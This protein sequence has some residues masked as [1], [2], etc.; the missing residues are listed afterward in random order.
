[1]KTPTLLRA[2]LLLATVLLPGLARAQGPN[3]IANPGFE[4]GGNAGFTSDY[5]YVAAP[6]AST[7][8]GSYTVGA[9]NKV[10]DSALPA[11]YG[12][13]TSGT[14]N[15]LIADGA[16]T[17]DPAPVKTVW[18]QDITGLTPNR[19]YTFSFW[20]MNTN[21]G[22][23]ASKAQI[24]A[25]ANDV[26][27]GLPYTN[28]DN[29]GVWNRYS[30]QVNPGNST[31]FTL[32]LR[33]LNLNSS[34]NDFGLD[35]L[36]LVESTADVTTTLTGPA[37]LGAG[38]SSGS[39][40]VT[41]TNNGPQ[42]AAQVTR[43]VALPAG[44][45]LT[46]A[47][48][49][50]LPNTAVYDSGLNTIT[51]EPVAILPSSSGATFAFSF[52]SPTALGNNSLTST[53]GTSTPQGDNK[54][55]D[56]ST[57]NVRVKASIAFVT[58][59]DSNEVPANGSKS[60][61]VILNDAN[62]AN[63][64]NS[65]FSAQV[66]TPPANGSL[67]LNA[68]GSYTYTPVV[69][70]KGPDSFTY[71]VNVPGANPQYSNVST[72]ALNVYQADL[73]CTSGTGPN[74]L[75]NPSFT[76]AS[77][78]AGYT[79]AYDYAGAGANSLVPE[80]LYMVGTDAHNYHN[81]FVGNG[82]KGAG[83]NFMIVN[84]SQ[85]LS[86]VYQQTV[87]VQ[88][89][90]YYTFSAYASSVNMESPAQLGFVI[91]GKSTSSVTTL[92][93]GPNAF[94]KI[95]DL[96]FSGESTQAV[97]EIRDV[98]KV[99]GGNDFGLDDLYIGTCTVYLTANDVLNPGISNQASAISVQPMSATV[100]NGGPPVGTFTVQTLPNPIAGTLYL[101]ASAVIPGQVITAANAGQLTFDPAANYTGSAVFTYSATD[102]SGS[103]SNNIAT[104]TIPID[105]RPLPVELTAFEVHAVRNLDAHLTW[106]TAQ[107]HKND[108]FDVERSFDGV[109]FARV[110]TVG[111]QGN[112]SGPTAYAYTDAG[113]GAAHTST[114]Y[115][116][117]RQVDH[118]NSATRSPV[119]TVAFE[120]AT[121]LS[122]YPNPTTGP[123]SLDLSALPAG[124]YQVTLVDATGR[125]VL[126]TA[127][128]GGQRHALPLAGLARGTYLLVVRGAGTKLSQHLVR[129]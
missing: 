56:A 102:E 87:T 94:V 108:H 41:F 98:N 38:V 125:Q 128:A 44:A 53:V 15:Y 47:Q 14:G 126:S 26:D 111:G 31:T 100:T 22:S 65:A 72:V 74:L 89:G 107:E 23:L 73:V 48:Q 5:F 118:D 97:I 95:S 124:N 96:W 18:A 68:N 42:A 71:K 6:G 82:R 63:L 27:T 29:A 86:V 58:N 30:V 84:G 13:H 32:R 91:N 12:D 61:N 88:A 92:G 66:V 80:G 116:R 35:D 90:R 62:P 70:Y 115:Y 37:V 36:E 52:T 43:V 106:T 20:L 28:A 75:I 1:M 105:P 16:A 120:G 69:D 34:A 45:S 99:K 67:T 119:R 57:V 24:Q 4:A 79:S 104:F 77:A 127:L 33:D 85:N 50:A 2:G 122:L 83:D 17:V 49:S 103:G 10:F 121:A 81:N 3:L 101:N 40:T 9:D 114:V 11:S 78:G 64:A 59:D 51:F 109:S 60:G 39:Y 25:S 112:A 8:P 76:N 21:S 55:P 54:A 113:V 46:V 110:A 19:F 93:T 123:A 7:G 117:L 129:E